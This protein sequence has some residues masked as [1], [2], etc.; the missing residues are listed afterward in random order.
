MVVLVALVVVALQEGEGGNC[1]VGWW[2]GVWGGFSRGC[3]LPLARSV[4]LFGIMVFPIRIPSQE[5]WISLYGERSF[6]VGSLDTS[7]WDYS[8]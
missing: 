5:G 3:L 1:L 8:K 6:R 2:F 7:L 4:D